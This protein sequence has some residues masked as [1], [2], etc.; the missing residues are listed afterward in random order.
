MWPAPVCFKVAGSWGLNEGTKPSPAQVLCIHIIIF[1]CSRSSFCQ[2]LQLETPSLCFLLVLILPSFQPFCKHLFECFCGSSTLFGARNPKVQEHY[3]LL[4]LYFSEE[5]D[6]LTQNYNA[7]SQVLVW[8]LYGCCHKLPQ[9]RWVKT[10]Y[11]G[12][13]KFLKV[14]SPNQFHWAKIRHQQ[15]PA[16]CGSAKGISVSLPFFQFLELHSLHP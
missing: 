1:I 16:P 5:T 15:G 9:T 8:I 3:C 4:K 7:V 10:T 14:R 2:S 11:T 13:F 6:A 12:S